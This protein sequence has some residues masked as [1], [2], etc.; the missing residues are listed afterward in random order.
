MRSVMLNDYE[1]SED[2]QMVRKAGFDRMEGMTDRI[3]GMTTWNGMATSR[4]GD[5]NQEIR[6]VGKP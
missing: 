3:N 5:V 2:D 4:A 1:W 6:A